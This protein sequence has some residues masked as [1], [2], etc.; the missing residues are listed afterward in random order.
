MNGDNGIDGQL[1]PLLMGPGIQRD[2]T[3]FSSN[4]WIDG[5]WVRFYRGNPKKM[6]GYRQLLGSLPNILRGTIII[7][8]SPNFNVYIADR[9]S[10]KYFQINQFGD[11]ISGLVDRTPTLFADNVNNNWQ[12]DVMFSS[13]SNSSNLIAY[14]AQNLGSISNS[15]ETP[16]YYGDAFANTP[17]VPT[18]LNTSGGIV[19]L[20]PYL[21]IYG[22]DGLISWTA[23]NDP[24]TIINTNRA[25]GSKIIYGAQSR[26]GNTSPAGLFWSLDS[27]IR[28][29]NVGPTILDLN[30]DTITTESSI[31]SSKGIIEYD[32]VF[33]WAASDRFLYYDGV[34]K[35]LPN[36]T[37]LNFFFQNI[38][39]SQRQKVWATKSSEWGEI[40]WHY[41]TGTNTECNRA[42]I[43]NVRE[44][45]WYDSES[46]RSCGDFDQVFQ[47]P[48]WAGNTGGAGNY[49]LWQHEYGN[50]QN[51]N[52][53]LTAID[54]YIQTGDISNCAVGP[55]GQFTGLDRWIE[56]YRLEPDFIPAVGSQ[57][58]G[59]M[60]LQAIG[61]E[62]ASAQ[63]NNSDILLFDGTTEKIDLRYQ[64]RLMSLKFRSFEVGG[65]F[66]MGRVLVMMRLGDG[67]Q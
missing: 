23:A 65:S 4:K 64:A 27:L 10:L 66:E 37:S 51:V 24:T 13:V 58:I 48:I 19:S 9:N 16:I 61:R 26:G 29:T 7:P 32:G 63:P 3:P 53:V 35:E 52:N 59:N 17:L 42:L 55:S 5:Q 11:Q 6:E 46:H 33:Y 50:D 21:F 20:Y 62:Y 57:N 22:N 47:Y 40:W 43:Y 31:L 30:F 14:A 1:Y 25:S 15:I 60:T 38:N 18:G 56:L 54:S 36:D 49:Q 39:Y 28:V 44:R 67:R 8:N 45:C 2:G 41:P 34:V 12:F